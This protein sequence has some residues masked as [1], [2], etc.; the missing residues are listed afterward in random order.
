MSVH[1]RVCLKMARG[2]YDTIHAMKLLP[3]HHTR[4]V[5]L[6]LSNS[7]SVNPNY[8]YFS[9]IAADS[10]PW[11]V[12]SAPTVHNKLPAFM[13]ELLNRNKHNLW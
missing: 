10:N 2:D 7:F 8:V 4:P 5:N 13:P 12:D 6:L 1:A 11:R 3:K 9:S